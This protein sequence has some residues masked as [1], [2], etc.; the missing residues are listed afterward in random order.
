MVV[1]LS[2]WLLAADHTAGAQSGKSPGYVYAGNVPINHS[3]PTGT[4]WGSIINK[5]AAYS[6]PG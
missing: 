2:R 4:W 1:I 6:E 3:D 5:L